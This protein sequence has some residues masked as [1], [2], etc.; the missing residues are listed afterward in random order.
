MVFRKEGKTFIKSNIFYVFDILLR[1]KFI[2]SN[3]LF[4]WWCIVR[5]LDACNTQTGSYIQCH[6]SA[7]VSKVWAI[8]VY[9]LSARRDL[10]A[11]YDSS[12]SVSALVHSLHQFNSSFPNC[13][14]VPAGVMVI[15]GLLLVYSALIVPMQVMPLNVFCSGFCFVRYEISAANFPGWLILLFHVRPQLSFLMDSDPCSLS[16]TAYFDLFVDCF[17]LVFCFPIFSYIASFKYSRC[18]YWWI[19]I[20][21]YFVCLLYIWHKTSVIRSAHHRSL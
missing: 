1:R 5:G 11:S 18:Q 3:A 4:S 13:I 20:I 14:F 2:S 9:R 12:I 7:Q 15:S 6:A 17:F 16:E 8:I 19:Y 21:R 10:A